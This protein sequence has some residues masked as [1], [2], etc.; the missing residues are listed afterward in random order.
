MSRTVKDSLMI[1]VG[2]ILLAAGA[3]LLKTVENPQ[4]V[5]QALPYI[6]LGC[7]CGV[8]GGGIG[9]LTGRKILEKNPEAK[10]LKEIEEKDER[11]RFIG[12]RA[13]AKAY[14][15]MISVFGALILVFT[16]MGMEPAPILMM[17]CAYL[18]VVGY[19]IY[20]RI[21]FEKTL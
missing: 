2:I 10:K 12:Y 18:F 15:V 6:C 1:A 11:N 20:Y 9:N 14:D 17:V 4:G 21:K 7:G 13:K 19:G 3:F 8:F 16:M 5:M